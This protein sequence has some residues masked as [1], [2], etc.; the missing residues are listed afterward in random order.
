M[1]ARAFVLLGIILGGA[2]SA[3]AQL[4]VELTSFFQP[5]LV[6]SAGS[7]LA[8][9]SQVR[10]GYFDST[11]DVSANAGS[12]GSLNTAFHTFATTS[13]FTGPAGPGQIGGSFSLNSG[14]DA[15]ESQKIFAWAF[16]TTDGGAPALDFNNVSEYGVFSS[17][18]PSWNF[19]ADAGAVPPNNA[20]SIATGDVNQFFHAS[21]WPSGG[22]VPN[23][24]LALAPVPEPGAWATVI[25]MGLVVFAAVRRRV[26]G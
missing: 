23:G 9:G 12:L 10:I 11:F 17:S 18:L 24:G 16:K 2:L 20:T 26:R 25:G 15:F 22:L 14:V 4:V 13:S 8:D 7:T 1:K 5:V 21:L 19:P 3:E 6:D